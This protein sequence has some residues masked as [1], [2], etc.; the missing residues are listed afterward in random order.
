MVV[1]YEHPLSPYAQKVKIALREKRSS[2]SPASPICSA[3]ATRVPGRQPAP[4][5]CRRWSTAT[6]RCS[7][8]PIILEYVEDRWPEPAAAAA[9]RRGARPRAH[10]RG[11]LRHLL[12]SDQLGGVRGARLSARHR[13]AGRRS[14]WRAPLSRSAGVNAY[15]DRQLGEQPVLQR[16]AT[17]AGAICRVVP[18][19]TPPPM[20]GHAPAA[21]SGLAAL[22]RAHARRG[23]ASRRPSTRR[24]TRWAASRCCPTWCASGISCASTATTAS[25]GCCAA[26]A[27]TIVLEGMRRKNI[28]FSHEL[29]AD[30]PARQTAMDDTTR[31]A[32]TAARCASASPSSATKRSSATARCAAKKANPAPDRAAPTASR[33]CAG[34][35]TL[36]TYRFNTGVAQ[37]TFCRICGIHPFYTPRSHPDCVDVNVR[38]LDGDACR[39]S[40]SHPSTARTGKRAWRA[41]RDT[42]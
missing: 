39:V 31:A 13:R 10:A 8:R 2:S 30:I 17:S 16:R 37:H 33:C 3:A 42:S 12:R 11:A 19:C 23:R 21:G 7:I 24:S 35:T 18:S 5:R 15:L 32:A 36:T 22:A 9:R 41:I 4:A 20:S 28:R 38:C 25:N 27:S 29:D 14:C 1:L 40:G 34:P 6:R 26:A